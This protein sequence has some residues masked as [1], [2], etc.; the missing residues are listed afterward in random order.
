MADRHG[1]VT[2]WFTVTA[3]RVHKMTVDGPAVEDCEDEDG[4]TP[5]ELEAFTRQR[6]HR[7]NEILVRVEIVSRERILYAI[8][9]T[10][11]RC[12]AAIIDREPA[13]EIY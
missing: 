6:L 5:V 1:Q 9:K 8:S 7:Q 2:R 11:F 12:H 4:L 10:E 3:Y 13:L